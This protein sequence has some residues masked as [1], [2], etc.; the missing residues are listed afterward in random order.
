MTTTNAFGRLIDNELQAKLENNPLY[1]QDGKK[2]DAKCI[3]VFRIGNIRWYVLE[4]QPEGT[5]FILY[6]IVVGMIDTEYG[7]MSAKEM[8]SLTIDASK[9]GLGILKVEHDK[10]FI[11]CKLSEIVDAEL[12]SFLSNMYDK[13]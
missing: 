12:Q 6:G 11:P 2:K 3:A 9:Y 13:E 4:G 8:S 10:T 1:S 5:D 7:Y